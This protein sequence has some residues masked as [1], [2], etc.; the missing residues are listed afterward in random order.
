MRTIEFR[1]KDIDTGKWFYGDLIQYGKYMSIRAMIKKRPVP[2]YEQFIVIPETVGQFIGEGVYKYYENDIVEYTDQYK[3]LETKDKY[4]QGVI[5]YTF[6]EWRIN[7]IGEWAG[8]TRTL[9]YN[10]KPIGNIHDN[11]ELI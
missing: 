5:V 11:P 10:F 2:E 8:S 4:F 9:N 3:S 1:G 6:G 7:G